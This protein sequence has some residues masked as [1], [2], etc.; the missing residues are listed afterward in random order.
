MSFDFKHLA[1]SALALAPVLLLGACGS[2]A[3]EADEPAEATAGAELAGAPAA[4]PTAAVTG[5]LEAAEGDLVEGE[6]PSPAETTAAA[7]TPTPTPTP[8]AARPSAAPATVA[9]AATPPPMWAVCG[10]CH[11]A[12]PGDHGIGPSLAG[13]FNSRAASKPGYDYSEAMESSGL[14]WNQATLDRYLTDP[15]GVVPGTT[16]AYN[17]LKNDAQRAAVIEYLKG[18]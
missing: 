4:T 16:M 8:A 10:A 9:A 1:A 5:G 13:V 18:L 3:Q 7:A 11:S 6:E 17:G 15:R 12:A 2:P 14:T